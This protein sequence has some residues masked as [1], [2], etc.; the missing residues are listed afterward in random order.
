MPS[1]AL[2]ALDAI[3]RE[4]VPAAI[5]RLAARAMVP[6]A[7]GPAG[8]E[9]LT[10]DEAAAL[11]KESRRYVYRHADELGAVRLGQRKLRFPR[12]RVLRRLGVGR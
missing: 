7:D 8:D 4:L 12:K 6:A 1:D 5:A 3:P 11:L 9:L 10:P 2:A